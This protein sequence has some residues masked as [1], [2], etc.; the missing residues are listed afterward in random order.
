[1]ELCQGGLSLAG[2]L[3]SPLFVPLKLVLFA[4]D[5]FSLNALGSNEGPHQGSVRGREEAGHNSA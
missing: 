5:A 1:M 4:V 3:I 2:A